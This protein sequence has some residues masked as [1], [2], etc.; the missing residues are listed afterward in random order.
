MGDDVFFIK[1]AEDFVKVKRQNTLSK[2]NKARIIAAY[3]NRP[4]LSRAAPNALSCLSHSAPLLG[5]SQLRISRHISTAMGEEE[6]NLEETHRKLADIEKDTKRALI[7]HNGF[8][9]E[10]GLPRLP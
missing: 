9:N 8:L 2:E 7:T 4:G 6:I 3:Q 1:A 10:L 5:S